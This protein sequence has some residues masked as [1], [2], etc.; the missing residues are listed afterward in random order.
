VFRSGSTATPTGLCPTPT[1]A[2]VA[3]TWFVATSIT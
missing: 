3:V 2:T 1:V